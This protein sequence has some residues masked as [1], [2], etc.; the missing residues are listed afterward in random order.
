MSSLTQRI[1]SQEFGTDG[2]VTLVFD[3]R[4]AGSDAA[5]AYVALLNT[6]PGTAQTYDGKLA[7]RESHPSMD[8]VYVDEN[9]DSGHYL[10][11]CRYSPPE[12]ARLAEEEVTVRISTA[13][14]TRHIT[15]S[16]STADLYPDPGLPGPPPDYL[17]AIGV[18]KDGVAGTDIADPVEVMTI[19]RRYTLA[20][21]PSTAKFHAVKGRVNSDVVTIKDTR[22]NRTWVA[23]PGE[24][25][26]EGY[27]E[28]TLD[29]D[30]LVTIAF[31]M[32]LSENRTDI[33]VGDI[34]D[35]VK[36]GWQHLWIDY[37]DDADDEGWQTKLPRA[38][39]VENVYR[40]AEMDG[41]GLDGEEPA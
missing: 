30:G 5:A 10:V 13:G 2:S 1:E 19:T 41:L 36:L 29:D 12:T 8:S 14:G 22:K 28:G 21:L 17:G 6:L 3:Y 37:W 26:C 33:V 40:T 27:D 31:Q 15:Q 11:R 9:T 23:N 7:I 38:A 34:T 32:A 35:I 16:Y 25:L 39:Y 18:T 4:D 24:L 20:N